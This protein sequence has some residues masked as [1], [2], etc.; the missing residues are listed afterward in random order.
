LG[1]FRERLCL[2]CATTKAISKFIPDKKLVECGLRNA[3]VGMYAAY[4]GFTQKLLDEAVA[5]LVSAVGFIDGSLSDALA[6]EVKKV[7]HQLKPSYLIKAWQNVLQRICNGSDVSSSRF[8][9]FRYGP[10]FVS[11]STLFSGDEENKKEYTGFV[12]SIEDCDRFMSLFSGARHV[13]AHGTADKTIN[14]GV[15]ADTG[16]ELEEI[17]NIELKKQ[18]KHLDNLLKTYKHGA[19][20][21]E[22]QTQWLYSVFRGVTIATTRLIA[23]WTYDAFKKWL[24]IDV[25]LWGFV[26]AM[27]VTWTGGESDVQAHHREL[28]SEIETFPMD[29]DASKTKRTKEIWDEEKGERGALEDKMKKERKQRSMESSLQGEERAAFLRTLEV[30]KCNELLYEGRKAQQLHRRNI[31]NVTESLNRKI[32]EDNAVKEKQR[33][34]R[35]RREEQLAA[36]AGQRI[37]VPIA[38]SLTHVTQQAEILLRKANQESIEAIHQA[39]MNGTEHHVTP[40]WVAG[41]G[42]C[43]FLALETGRAVFVDSVE[44]IMN[45]PLHP[46][47]AQFQTLFQG[48]VFVGQHGT[49]ERWLAQIRAG[50]WAGEFE[51][52]L[53]GLIAQT[54]IRVFVLGDNN[55][56]HQGTGHVFGDLN[57]TTEAWIAFVSMTPVTQATASTGNHYIRLNQD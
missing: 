44:K 53:I 29:A 26:P 45:N 27:S 55:F 31:E 4:E 11:T 41:H 54:R 57:S 19:T 10:Q 7:G 6:S 48:D 3:C 42:D 40:Q 50:L 20:I 34:F 18:A 51:I 1:E 37:A 16:K 52:N 28:Q 32:E 25:H 38:S 35:A 36:P 24:G 46:L 8:D 47:H 49:Y 30:K 43:A 23:L 9:S 5:E 33:I 14:E 39:F 12:F 22:R 56:V 13:F 15:L 17:K 21:S 2:Q